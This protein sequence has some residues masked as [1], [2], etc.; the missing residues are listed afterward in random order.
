VNYYHAWFN[1]VDTSQDLEFCRH[2][3]RF[4]GHLKERGMIEGYSFARR[5]LGLGPPD[6]GEFHLA[7][8]VKNLEQLDIAFEHAATRGP[9]VEPLHRDVF[10]AIKDVKFAL[11]RDFPDSVRHGLKD[12]SD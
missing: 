6:L 12:V 8:E 9:D 1:L 10:S 4:L 2:V 3:E 5:K 7:I 11:Y